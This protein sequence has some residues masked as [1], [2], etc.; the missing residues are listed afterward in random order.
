MR[1]RGLAGRDEPAVSV[2]E[3]PVLRV[4][5]DASIRLVEV[6]TELQLVALKC[7]RGY[8]PFRVEIAGGIC[9]TAGAGSANPEILIDSDG[10]RGTF[11]VT[12]I[13]IK[14]NLPLTGF[15]FLSV[16]SLRIDGTKYDTRTQNLIE[17]VGTGVEESADLMG[18]PIRVD[19]LGGTAPPTGGRFPTQ[20]I[21]DSAGTDDIRIQ[22]FCRSDVSD[23]D[24]DIV[25]VAGWK[26]PVDTITVTYVPGL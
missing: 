16:N 10:G 3:V 5:A 14:T 17:F 6:R 4:E 26:R 19:S 18:T 20:I 24:L 2:E 15:S 9:N 23:L 1:E 13:L 12:S 7:G 8:V 22:L 21:A 25:S 11:V